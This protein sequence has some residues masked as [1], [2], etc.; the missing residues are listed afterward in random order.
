[1]TTVSRH[2]AGLPRVPLAVLLLTVGIVVAGQ[3]V[4][5]LTTS[6]G[7][8]TT[9][10]AETT[11]DDVD[12]APDPLAPARAVV[13][14]DDLERIRADVAF[15]GDRFEKSPRDFISATRLGISEIELARATGDITAYLAASVALD[16][17]LA[18]YPDYGPARDYRGVV[19]VALHRF[20]DARENAKRIL[21]TNP[22][23]LT[24]LAT[25][26][27]ASLEL[28]DLEAARDAF[29]RLGAID[30]SAAASVRIGHLAFIEGRTDDAVRAAREA[31]KAAIAEDTGGSAL[32]W[33][34]YQLGDTLI[35]TGDRAGAAQAYADASAADPRSHLAHWGLA[36]VAAADGRLDEAI[37]QLDSAIAAVPLPEFVA[38]RA[39]L[40]RLRGA[41]GDAGRE[42]DDRA[43]VLA[44]AKLWGEGAGDAAAVH[45][46]TLSLYLAGPGSDPARALTL[47]QGEIAVRKDVYG[48]DALAW[49]LLANDRPAEADAAMKSALAFGTHDAKLLYH[50]GM[51]AS[52]LGDT[53][54][55]RSL[56]SEA[57]ALDPSFDPLA[58]ATATDILAGLR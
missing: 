35:A 8:P 52:A 53:G 13:T 39:D 55:A 22:D 44:I 50:A 58:A 30:D 46:R 54:R 24:A 45:D 37:A 57:L 36:R 47:A 31:V 40:Y 51:I 21:V 38:R 9:P 15:W 29:G 16:G 41:T 10:A 23:D 27:D 11:N 6:P 26:G 19:L 3:V 17:A 1:M 33:Y 32:A 5:R 43:T 7:A 25:L 12:S 49:A 14:T 2:L 34:R 18:A 56:L 42:S 28:G 4:P 20:A 48:Y